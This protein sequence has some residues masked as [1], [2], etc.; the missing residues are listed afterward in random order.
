MRVQISKKGASTLLE[1]VEKENANCKENQKVKI[2]GIT[3]DKEDLDEAEFSLVQC[4]TS[5]INI[6]NV[7]GGC[8]KLLLK[9]GKPVTSSELEM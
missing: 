7:S 5:G 8:K 1:I 2:V 4:I 9:I 6:H 3:L